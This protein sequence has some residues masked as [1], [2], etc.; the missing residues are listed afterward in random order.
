M[1]GSV[2]VRRMFPS[3]KLRLSGLDPERNYVVV[4]DMVGVDEYRYKYQDSRWVVAG[5]ADQPVL[6]R[7]THVHVDSPAPG[8]HWMSRAVSFHKLKLTNNV[9]DKHAHVCGSMRPLHMLADSH[10]IAPPVGRK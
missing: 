8:R 3:L 4:L 10:Y 6:G 2:D 5:K 9:V 1:G 7:Q